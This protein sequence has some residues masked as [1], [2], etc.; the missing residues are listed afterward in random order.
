[1]ERHFALPVRLDGAPVRAAVGVDSTEISHAVGAFVADMA[2]FL[3]VIGA[4]LLVSAWTQVTVGLRPLAAVREG[5]TRIRDGR[6]QRLGA[7]FPE[8][9]KPLAVELDALLDARDAQIA[10]AR[11]RAGDLAHGLKTPLQVLAGEADRLLA[12]GECEI[13]TEVTSLVATMHLHIEH[14]LT[15]ARLAAGALHARANVREVAERVTNVVRRTPAGRRLTWSIDVAPNLRAPIDAVDLGEAL[16]NLIE[17]A[18]RH[19]RSQVTVSG[20]SNGDGVTVTVA[21]DGPGIPADRV[22]DA[23]S[24]GVRLDTSSPGTGLGLAIVSE[25]AEAWGACLSITDEGPG[26]KA[27]L[28]F[29]A[30]DGSRSA[31]LRRN[32]GTASV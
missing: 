30:C 21:D 31:P 5:L 2:P 15:R 28:R 22:A 11:A 3:T 9:V 20:C 4:L 8:E 27:S 13:A 16:G 18:A 10:K 17:N 14:E 26:L 7:G 19:A 29:A 25:I 32:P 24:R 23:L 6:T 12:K 1:V